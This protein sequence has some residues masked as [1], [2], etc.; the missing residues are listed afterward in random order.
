MTKSSNSNSNKYRSKSDTLEG[1]IWFNSTPTDQVKYVDRIRL[2]YRRNHPQAPS[3]ALRTLAEPHRLGPQTRSRNAQTLG[4]C[5]VHN[6]ALAWSKSVSLLWACF[7]GVMI[8]SVIVLRI[9]LIGVRLMLLLVMICCSIMMFV[10]KGGVLS[11]N[12][13]FHLS[14]MDRVEKVCINSSLHYSND[15]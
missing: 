14:E 12:E 6:L 5:T 3:E 4:A 11:G 8:I 2:F 10:T 7:T 1:A 13:M 9:W 15:I